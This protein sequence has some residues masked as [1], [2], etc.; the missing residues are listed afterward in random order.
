MTRLLVAGSWRSIHVVA[1]DGMNWL[2]M[3]LWVSMGDLRAEWSV[4]YSSAVEAAVLVPAG[5]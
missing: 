3:K 1:F 4:R 2:S 5:L